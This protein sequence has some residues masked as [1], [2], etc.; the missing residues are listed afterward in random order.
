M[1]YIQEELGKKSL[2]KDVSKLDFD[3]VPEDLPHREGQLRALARMFGPILESPVSESLLITGSVGTGKTAISKRFLEDFRKYAQQRGTVVES[4]R[5]NC[6]QRRTSASV[7][8]KI[9]NHF[10]PGFPDRGFSTDEM[11]DAIRKH[12]ERSGCHLIVVL[13]EVDVLIKKS[14]S[15]LL[16]MFT[17][18]DEE[19]SWLKGSLSLICISQYRVFDQLD[20]AARSTIGQTNV[21]E[22]G[23]YDA[24]QLLAILEQ[25]VG[26]AFKENTVSSD[27]LS[28]IADTAAREGDARM[29][30]ELLRNAGQDA[31]DRGMEEIVPENVRS[32]KGS[33]ST[34]EGKAEDLDQHESLTLLAVARVLKKGS[35]FATTGEVEKAYHRECEGREVRPRAHTQFW[36]YLKSL[37]AQGFIT[38]EKKTANRQGTT[39]MIS[40]PDVAATDLIAMME[41][42]LDKGSTR[43]GRSGKPGK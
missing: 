41:E 26:L 36:G 6:R 5:V 28:L 7:L 10:Q 43:P 25:R 13:D 9:V 38:T 21:I 19:D 29:A 23:K 20:A 27:A 39:S 35:A 11:M 16:Y 12:I 17:R 18:F 2:F 32:A 37:D 30:I 3:Y 24:P 42:H 1:R 4:V 40:L 8:L 33:I 14:G 34:F 15:D 31:S 22:C